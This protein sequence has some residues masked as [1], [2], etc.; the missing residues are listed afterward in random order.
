MRA[1]A[2]VKHDD[3]LPTA[4]VWMALLAASRATPGSPQPVLLELAGRP[5]EDPAAMLPTLHPGSGPWDGRCFVI[6][7]SGMHSVPLWPAGAADSPAWLQP[8]VPLP[9]AAADIALHLPPPD[10]VLLRL[11]CPVLAR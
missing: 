9:P 2:G 5:H 6:L 11:D 4:V 1:A 10:T 7:S 3:L 8:A